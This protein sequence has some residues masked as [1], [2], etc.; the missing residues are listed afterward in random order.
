MRNSA[1]RK[2]SIKKML[3]AIVEKLGDCPYVLDEPRLLGIRPTE[4]M[5]ISLISLVGDYF[6]FL[7]SC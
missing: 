1:R 6:F 4:K 3:C 7:G 2:M 5:D